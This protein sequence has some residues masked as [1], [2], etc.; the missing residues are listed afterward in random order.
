MSI[1]LSKD[2]FQGGSFQLRLA[3]TKKII[4]RVTNNGFGDAVFFF[5]FNH[6]VVSGKNVKAPRR[7]EF[8]LPGSVAQA[9]PH[10]R[11]RC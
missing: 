6:E 11:S 2:V 1:N 9:A 3:K 4:R 10:A 8:A 5:D 7:L